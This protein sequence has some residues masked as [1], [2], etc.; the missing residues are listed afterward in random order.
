[1]GFSVRSRAILDELGH[2]ARTLWSDRNI[3]KNGLDMVGV[4]EV[5]SAGRVVFRYAG[6]R[7]RRTATMSDL[8]A[9]RLIASAL[10]AAISSFKRRGLS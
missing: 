10:S 1:M 3:F 2:V 7:R 5:F 4:S 6:Q 8:H 9:A